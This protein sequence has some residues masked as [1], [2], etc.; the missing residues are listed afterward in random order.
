[1]VKNPLS[2][3]AAS[4]LVLLL[5][6]ATG[7][8][9][10]TPPPGTAAPFNSA[11]AKNHQAAWAKHLGTTVEEKNSLGMAMVLL[12]PGEFQMGSSPAQVAAALE[13]LKQIRAAPGENRRLSDEEALRH[14]VVL[15]RPFRVGRTEVTIGQFRQFVAASRYVTET[16]L[17]GG[18]NS[19]KVVELDPKKRSASWREPGY[20][21]TDDFPVTQ[22][23]W[24]DMIAFTNWL[25]ERERRPVGYRRNEQ[26]SWIRIAGASGYR[27]PTEAEWEYAC[28]AGTTTHY[29]FGDDV[30]ELDH[31]AWYNRTAETKGQTG[32]RPVATR[33]PN[34]FGLF[35]MH[36]NV[37]ERCQDYYD[38]AAYAHSRLEDPEGPATGVNRIARGGG[39]HYFDLHARSAYRNNYS[40]IFRTGNAGFRVVCGI[41]AR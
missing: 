2:P 15:T 38:A 9:G 16:E 20:K 5:M 22:V 7:C 33:R 14:R 29:S 10:A 4:A 30:G 31:Y 28:R 41:S 12:P 40:P 1:M 3:R 11:Q 21:V 27:L 18:G 39:W 23:T 17:F 19:S 25:N 37:W 8:V 24:N 13:W 26:G 34:P 32:A 35:D 6:F 36:G